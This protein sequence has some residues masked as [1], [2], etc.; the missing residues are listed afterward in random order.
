MSPL[1]APHDFLLVGGSLILAGN[2]FFTPVKNKK[3]C[4]LVYPLVW[5][6]RLGSA[7]K[8]ERPRVLRAGTVSWVLS[9]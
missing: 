2:V 8:R 9:G 4:G 3:K 7:L 6:T 1:F 5:G